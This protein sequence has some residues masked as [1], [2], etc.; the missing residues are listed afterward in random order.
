MKIFCEVNEKG[1]VLTVRQKCAM[2]LSV[3]M[4]KISASTPFWRI[5]SKLQKPLDSENPFISTI[6]ETMN[7]LNQYRF[8]SVAALRQSPVRATLFFTVLFALCLLAAT[9]L[10]RGQDLS[11]DTAP[12]ATTAPVYSDAV[13][14]HIITREVADTMIKRWN[15]F[16]TVF[17]P[18]PSQAGV[19]PKATLAFLLDQRQATGIRFH[20]GIDAAGQMQAILAAQ[21]VDNNLILYPETDIPRG[22][23]MPRYNASV[24]EFANHNIPNR[25]HAKALVGKYTESKWFGLF[26]AKYG[27]TIGKEAI[28]ALIQPAR[29]AGV[30]FYFGLNATN[31]PQLIYV[32]VQEDGKELWDVMLLDAGRL[33]PPD[34]GYPENGF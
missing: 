23:L 27:G 20:L 29:V 2:R 11:T 31:D 25:T 12:D 33:C 22:L 18:N 30:K 14:R 6:V 21:G 13:K 28:L 19:L 17:S 34:C 10:L 3:K 7:S 4:K 24:K 8:D 16:G 9:T 32:P 26:N 15:S 5:F 1:V